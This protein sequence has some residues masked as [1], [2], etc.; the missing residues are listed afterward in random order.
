MPMEI[1]EL[2]NTVIEINKQTKKIN[3][4]LNCI[5]GMTEVR[6]NKL[7]HRTKNIT[8]NVAQKDEK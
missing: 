1:L 5:L 7:E 4:G 8:Q 6:T 2:K 3:R